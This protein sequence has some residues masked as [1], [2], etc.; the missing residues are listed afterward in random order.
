MLNTDAGNSD[1]KRYKMLQHCLPELSR[2][3]YN[4]KFKSKD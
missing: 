3:G 1:G 2:K 4:F